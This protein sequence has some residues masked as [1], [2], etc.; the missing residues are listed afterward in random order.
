MEEARQTRYEGTK[1]WMDSTRATQFGAWTGQ[2]TCDEERINLEDSRTFGVKD[3]SWGIRS[4]G[5]PAPAAPALHAPQAFFLWAPLHFDDVAL[6]GLVFEDELGKPW[7]QTAAALPVIGKDEPTWGAEPELEHFSAMEHQVR[8]APGL[9]RS[10]GATLTF[11]RASGV[12]EVVELA[13]LLTFRMR[14]AGYGHPRWKHGLWHG[15]FEMGGESHS[16][17]ELDSLDPSCI[18][19]QQVVRATWGSRVGIGVLE[20]AVIG[21]HAPSGFSELLDGA[22]VGPGS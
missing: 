4:V 12:R 11:V 1:L 14:G 9:R 7:S 5:E 20:Q 3:R 10:E 8:W 22:R 19:V 2:I 6:H 17:E 21:P 15:E 18:H 16:V 13:P